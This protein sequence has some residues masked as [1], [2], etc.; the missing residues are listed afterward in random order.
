MAEPRYRVTITFSMGLFVGEW[1]GDEQ[2]MDEQS[3][4]LCESPSKEYAESL[5]KRL[6]KENR[7][8]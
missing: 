4:I 1:A 6:V 2:E 8:V 3:T 5:Y 7:R